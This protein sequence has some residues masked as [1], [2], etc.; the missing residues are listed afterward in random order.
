LDAEDW[1]ALWECLVSGGVLSPPA[2]SA[3]FA[4]GDPGLISLGRDKNED[5]SRLI[6]L[7]L[8]PRPV[9]IERGEGRSLWQVELD[10]W[11]G[12]TA[13]D[14]CSGTAVG[15]ADADDEDEDDAELDADRSGIERIS[16]GV[17]GE[18]YT[19]LER[20]LPS[21]PEF[22][23]ASESSSDKVLGFCV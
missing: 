21:P 12:D 14:L 9:L 7:L 22:S 2:A 18:G 17:M 8:L 4:R 10:L 16:D 13:P 5:A 1:L 23:K 20:A 19:V 3:R 15:E 6:A 11:M